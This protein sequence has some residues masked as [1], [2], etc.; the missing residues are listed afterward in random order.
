[1]AWLTQKSIEDFLLSNT[2][3]LR[4]PVVPYINSSW[5]Y[6]KENILCEHVKV[7]VTAVFR[8]GASG[9]GQWNL[10]NSM[11]VLMR[12]ETLWTRCGC[13]QAVDIVD[14]EEV[15]NTG[16]NAYHVVDSWESYHDNPT[17]EIVISPVTLN[18][19]GSEIS[20][21]YLLFPDHFIHG[22]LIPFNIW[23]KE[24]GEKV[25]FSICWWQNNKDSRQTH[26]QKPTMTS[27]HRF[28]K[29]LIKIPRANFQPGQ[30]R[31]SEI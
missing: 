18:I 20:G 10:R 3:H 29:K 12:E 7:P 6:D 19:P 14:R 25:V 24:T 5:R 27:D 4:K 9:I 17:A 8:P 2:F 13:D 15:C 31:F 21:L 26:I 28:P 30:Y 23:W 16:E 11:G 1:M 22:W